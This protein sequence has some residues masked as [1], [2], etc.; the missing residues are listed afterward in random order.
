MDFGQKSKMILCEHEINTVLGSNAFGKHPAA[1]KPPKER[2]AKKAK[3]EGI[4]G[5]GKGNNIKKKE[6]RSKKRSVEDLKILESLPGPPEFQAY[7][8]PFPSHLT[9][10]ILPTSIA[11]NLKPLEL[12]NLFFSKDVLAQIVDNTNRYVELKRVSEKRHSLSLD[13]MNNGTASTQAQ[14]S[15]DL[16][17]MPIVEPLESLNP[18]SALV[19]KSTCP[20]TSQLTMTSANSPMHESQAPSPHGSEVLPS[21]N[22]KKY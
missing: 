7:E 2:F 9:T 12:F 15:L 6:E 17:H 22:G 3:A 13:E 5:G 21:M 11:S 8:S 18:D 1:D 4:P 20:P 19:R 10:P 16:F 14:N